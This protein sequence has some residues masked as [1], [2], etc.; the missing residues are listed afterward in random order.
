MREGILK[1]LGK[2]DCKLVLFYPFL[3]VGNLPSVKESLTKCTKR[4]IIECRT[5]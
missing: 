3:R 5:F 1:N 2:L 4:A